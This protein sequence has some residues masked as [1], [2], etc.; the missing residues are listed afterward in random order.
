LAGLADRHGARNLR[1]S[2]LG[3]IRHGAALLFDRRT[4]PRAGDRSK[5]ADQKVGLLVWSPLAGGLLSGKFDAKAK[6]ADARRAQMDFPIVVKERAWACI[7]A[8]RG[9]AREY[10]TSVARVALAWILSKGFVTSI[11]IGAKTI[12]Q[13]NDN[14]G[15][16]AL[17]LSAAELAS[18][19]AISEL[20]PE[21]PGWIAYR[22]IN[23]SNVLERDPE[24]RRASGYS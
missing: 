13:L 5:I 7:E 20:A 6:P 17:E 21:Y 19:D 10:A 3:D 18:L 23:R 15:A 1:A 24:A 8:M 2:R 4:R 11:I 14:L 22:G 9:I 12:E 16:S